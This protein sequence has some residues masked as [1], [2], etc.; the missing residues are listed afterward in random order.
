MVRL[1]IHIGCQKERDDYK[2]C[3]LETVR[4]TLRTCY[5]NIA[6]IYNQFKYVLTLYRKITHSLCHSWYLKAHW[7]SLFPHLISTFSHK[8]HSSINTLLR[9]VKHSNWNDLFPFRLLVLYMFCVVVMP[10]ISK[11]VI[12][13]IRC[14]QTHRPRE[15]LIS[16]QF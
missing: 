16:A 10:D 7:L 15:S 5:I 1:F 12:P 2:N 13:Y 3:F 8:F 4:K 14:I 9:L 6:L 11:V